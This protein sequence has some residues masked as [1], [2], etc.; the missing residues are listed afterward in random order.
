M[1]SREPRIET[2]RLGNVALTMELDAEASE[3]GMMSPAAFTEADPSPTAVLPEMQDASSSSSSPSSACLSCASAAAQL[4][5]STA[6]AAAK[7]RHTMEDV[8]EGLLRK[9]RKEAK[10]RSGSGSSL[11]E[12]G[13]ANVESFRKSVSQSGEL[14]EE[15]AAAP[16]LTATIAGTA[17]D[18]KAVRHDLDDLQAMLV[19]KYP[20]CAASVL[21]AE[22]GQ[23]ASLPQG[24]SLSLEEAKAVLLAASTAKVVA[25]PTTAEMERRPSSDDGTMKKGGQQPLHDEAAWSAAGSDGLSV[26]GGSMIAGPARQ[27][28]P[29]VALKSCAGDGTERQRAVRIL[30]G[31]LQR[32]G[33]AVVVT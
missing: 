33:K 13:A 20:D 26:Q 8:H 32:G 5:A 4:P 19:R 14:A 25:A 17:A 12:A 22:E 18:V 11:P 28:R 9:L 7:V 30:A 15:E 24:L 23:P 10:L 2:D 6:D 3:V 27:T 31:R 1:G 16:A 21:S 29:S